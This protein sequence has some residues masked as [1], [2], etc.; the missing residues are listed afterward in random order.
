MT[1]QSGQG[2]ASSDP[3]QPAARHAH[4]G[5]VLPADGSEPLMPGT[6]GDHAAPPVGSPW[7]DPWGPEPTSPAPGAG[8]AW[9]TPQQ[10]PGGPYQAPAAPSSGA[11]MPLPPE[12]TPLP[13]AAPPGA[14]GTQGMAL[15][16]EGAG[17][18]YA[19]MP[20]QGQGQIPGH[21]PIPAEGHHMPPHGQELPGASYG[22]TNA[23][24]GGGA[25]SYGG[26][27]ASYAQNSGD[28]A[29]YAQ[30]SGSEASYGQNSGN[31]AAY[32]QS[33]G[34][35]DAAYGRSGSPDVSYGGAHAS[36]PLPPAAQSMPLP[37]AGHLPSAGQHDPAYGGPQPG[38][39]QHAGP[40]HGGHHGAQPGQPGTAYPAGNAGNGGGRHAAAPV[41]ADAEATQFIAPV[42]P[43]AP[44]ALPP[45]MPAVSAT[46]AMP[47]G[48]ATQFLGRAQDVVPSAAAPDDNAPTQFIAPVTDGANPAAPH[49]AAAYG[50]RPGAP[51]DRQPP[52]EF[53]SLFRREPEPDEGPASTQQMPRFQAP[54]PTPAFEPQPE[55]ERQSRGRGGRGGGSK[56]PLLAAVGVGIAVLGVGAG[57][58][59][60][61]GGGDD[62]K[63]DDNQPLAATAPAEDDDKPSP[64]P[65]P[66]KKQ[67][68]ALDK[69]L[70]DSND[71]RESVIGAV[72]DVGGCKNLKQAATDLRAAAE[73]RNGLV[74]RLSGLTVDELPKHAQLTAALNK[75][76][77]ASASA[78]NHYAAWAGQVA[79]KKGCRKGH[80]RQTNHSAAGNRA[81]G[82]ATQAKQQAATLWNAIAQQHGLTKRVKTQL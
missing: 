18:G 54:A 9:D 59:L 70:A 75:A 62:D 79:G 51:E 80:A 39:G 2:A 43:A 17:Q 22:G 26:N 49:A 10:Q 8:A 32:G 34:S 33:G 19:P 3:Q 35:N 1:Q 68:V 28:E 6:T 81:S 16:P 40:A 36:A 67:A 46:S 47:D 45:E 7:G 30:N 71:S 24:Y 15:P 82:E 58:L 60:S 56:M 78:D 65:D 13:P 23:A 44:G 63:K 72:R 5:I 66:A 31:A 41:G 57:A 76:W 12:G 64:T 20:G 50:V 55:P 25:A 37:P 52:A 29:S 4:E 53:D 27:E 38:T 21:G 48:G 73:Q 14:Y 77:K 74:G 61:G 11:G 42:P 69:L